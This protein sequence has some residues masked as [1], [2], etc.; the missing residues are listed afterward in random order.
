[1]LDTSNGELGTVRETTDGS[2]WVEYDRELTPGHPGSKGV[3]ILTGALVTGALQAVPRNATYASLEDRRPPA[4]Q[5]AR[6]AERRAHYEEHHGPGKRGKKGWT[7]HR[8]GCRVCTDIDAG[9]DGTGRQLQSV[10]PVPTVAETETAAGGTGPAGGGEPSRYVWASPGDGETDVRHWRF[11]AALDA[12]QDHVAGWVIPEDG[13]GVLDTDS[14][15]ASIGPYVG[16]LGTVL[17]ELGEQ[18]GSG[19]TPI[20]PVVGETLADFAAAFTAMAG[21]AAEVYERWVSNEDN[22]HDLRRARGEIPGA[23]LFNVGA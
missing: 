16:A 15:I 11:A 9:G 14:F 13:T 2:V 18:F 4:E 22:A 3:S 7:A 10:P 20:A 23:H 8:R 6:Y 12:L 19:E 5:A 1:V 21:E 17:G